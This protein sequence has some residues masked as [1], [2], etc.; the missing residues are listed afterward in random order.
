MI[1]GAILMGYVAFVLAPRHSWPYFDLSEVVLGAGGFLLILIG[2]WLWSGKW[3]GPSD[4]P[5]DYG[6]GA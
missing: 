3:F 2:Y 1:G 6:P 5:S 4:W